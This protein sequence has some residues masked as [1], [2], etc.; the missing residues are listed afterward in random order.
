MWENFSEVDKA[1]HQEEF[2]HHVR[3]LR[4]QMFPKITKVSLFAGRTLTKDFPKHEEY[5]DVILAHTVPYRC[6]NM[7]MVFLLSCNHLNMD[8][9]DFDRIQNYIWKNGFHV[10]NAERNVKAL[11]MI[12]RI[13][14]F[15]E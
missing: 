15:L 11:T 1:T 7:L 2:Y 3:R 5:I 14:K 4:K 8:R 13:D 6:S 12:Q 9:A 10:D